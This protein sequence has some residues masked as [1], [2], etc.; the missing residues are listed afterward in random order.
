M[1]GKGLVTPIDRSGGDVRRR[2]LPRLLLR[3]D[4]SRPG[5][6]PEDLLPARAAGDHLTGRLRR[7][8]G[9]RDLPPAHRRPQVGRLLLRR[10]PHLGDLRGRRPPDRADLG[11]GLVGPLVGLER[12]D[13]G[14]LPDRLPALRDLLPLPLRDRGPRAPGALRLGLRGHRRRLRAAQL[15][16]RAGIGEPRP[17]ARVRNRRRRAAGLD[18]AGLRR[19]P[20]SDGAAL[21]DPG[22]VRALGE[23]RVRPIDRLR[24]AIDAPGSATSSRVAPEVH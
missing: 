24:R 20:G 19:L 17:P 2:A 21:G 16:G 9:L 14:Q 13:A 10:D 1:Y 18:D 5:L 4:R 23:E 15:H 3:P 8:R 11:E 22:Q 7:R 6:H 12:T